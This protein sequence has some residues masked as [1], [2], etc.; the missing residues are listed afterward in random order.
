MLELKPCPFCGGK[1]EIRRQLT[2]TSSIG[3]FF[4]LCLTC[5]TSSDNY[6]SME[7]A[8]DHWNR[9]MYHD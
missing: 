1:A 6:R 2:S 4:V 7:V 9:R 5:L 3:G 8:A